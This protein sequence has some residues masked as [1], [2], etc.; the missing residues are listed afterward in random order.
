MVFMETGYN[1]GVSQAGRAHKFILVKDLVDK[2]VQGGIPRSEIAVVAG[3]VTPEQK[4]AIADKMNDG[5]LR[6]AI[7]QTETLGTGVNAQRQLRAIHHL[8]APWRPGDLEQRNGRGERQGN[9]WNTMQEY[10]Y[11]TEGIDGR[12]WQVLTS[13]DGFIKKFINAFNDTSGKRL[14][15]MEVDSDA[16]ADNED[17]SQTLSAAA[18]DPRI[19]LRAK[20]KG[21]VTRLER[22]ERLH[23]VGQADALGQV[24]SSEREQRGYLADAKNYTDW[25]DTWNA[26]S[27]RAAEQAGAAGDSRRWYEV[28]GNPQE[29]EEAA[30]R[31]DT[32]AA[33]RRAGAHAG[34]GQRLPHQNQVV[35]R[36]SV[37]ALLD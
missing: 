30:G 28:G 15:A 27:Q 3:G 16:V 34:D 23:T 31:F 36:Q 14:G 26:A 20:Y 2:L 37:T 25:G 22:R 9:E 21:D 1:A 4:K 5:R 12:R 33:E 6:V 17:M 32:I 18:G 19:M 24:R 7:G 8:D 29:A 10:R 13:K 35:S 11:I